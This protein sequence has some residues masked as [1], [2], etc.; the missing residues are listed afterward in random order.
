MN[1]RT[2]RKL[3]TSVSAAALLATAYGATQVL[4]ADDDDGTPRL[5]IE[6]G[7]Q[8]ERA[9]GGDD[10]FAPPFY[11]RIKPPIDSPAA[12]VDELPWALGQDGKVSFQPDGSDWIFSGG[13]RFGRAKSH[14]STHQQSQ[15]PQKTDV[16]KYLLQH[17]VS[18][19]G[20]YY[21]YKI[22][23]CHSQVVTPNANYADV[24]S[25]HQESHV[26]LDFQAGKDVGLGL[27]GA[28]STSTVSGGVRFAQ[29]KTRTNIAVKARTDL[30]LYNGF[31][32]PG[33]A[34]FASGFPQ[35]YSLATNH[36]EFSL[37]AGSERNFK[38]VGPSI[39]WE[40]SATIAGNPDSSQL[41]FD[42]GV[43]AALL[44]GKQKSKTHH[45]S[46]GLYQK[47]KYGVIS[48]YNHPRVHFTR[49]RNVTIPN[50]GG[51]AGISVKWPNAKV[52]IGYRAD[53]FFNAM[54]GGWDTAKKENRSFMGPFASI[55]VG[56]GD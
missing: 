14:R 29:F 34:P 30:H 50:I 18:P 1:A 32:L 42:W 31:T 19:G 40:A 35:K 6:L 22:K 13:I 23:C 47:S 46:S 25:L 27:L 52:S 49:S 9:N 16:E 20:Q 36:R 53:V 56:L 12:I 51:M 7:A 15:P 43:N 2:R 11:S 44:F 21:Y 37:T 39:S 45:Q 28:Q 26:V 5:W 24:Q 38:G 55:S 33:Y 54:D 48:S 41:T 10:A 4:A 3:L 17:Y 8:L